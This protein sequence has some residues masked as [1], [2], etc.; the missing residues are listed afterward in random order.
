[1]KNNKPQKIYTIIEIDKQTAVCKDYNGEELRL[2]K[3][4]IPLEAMVGSKLY[5][6]NFSMYKIIKE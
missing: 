4:K 3:Y 6:D 1:M 5:Q 2:D